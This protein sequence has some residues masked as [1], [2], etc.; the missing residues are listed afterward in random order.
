MKKREILL[1]AAIVAISLVA[2]L[3]YNSFNSSKSIGKIIDADGNTVLTF[4]INEDGYYTV[5]GDYGSFNLEV[6]DRKWRAVDVECPN[7]DCEN[8]GWSSRD[9]YVPIICLPNRLW[10]VL[11]E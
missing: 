11:D 5:E 6:K 4:D 8:M 2:L 10:V 3:V 1:I 7:H 9:I